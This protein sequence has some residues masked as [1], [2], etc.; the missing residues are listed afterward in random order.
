ML[1]NF[2]AYT[3]S[4][5]T[6]ISTIRS[7]NW[8]KLAKLWLQIKNGD[9]PGWS[10][11]KALEYMLIRAFDLNGAEVA[12][13]YNNRVVNSKE[14][15]DGYIF[16]PELGVGFLLECKDW[17]TSVSFDELAKLH[18]RLS[19]RMPSTYGIYVSKNGFTS[20]AVEMLYMMHPHN[21]LLWSFDEIDECFKNQKFLKALK[22]KYQ[23]AMMT[24]DP[25]IAV[26]E[27]IN[28]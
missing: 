19:Y 4:E 3:N 10:F 18:S 15:F 8:A 12:Y 6:M 11:G 1:L 21:I 20:S 17:K 27:G 28:I 7:Y 24:A 14:Q 25:N 5:K 23:Y 13:P 9:T 2:N 22:Y 16:V 26:F